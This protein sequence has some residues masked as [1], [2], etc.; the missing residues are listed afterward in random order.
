MSTDFSTDPRVKA[1]REHPAVGHG[2]CSMI[3]ECLDDRE[4]ISNLDSEKITD[5]VEAVRWALND[6][7]LYWERGLNC[8]SGEPETDN[9][10]RSP[11]QRALAALEEFE[12]VHGKK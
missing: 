8:L 4:L 7:L 12:R 1:I 11:Y 3:D 6:D 2:S 10:L 5:P 9:R